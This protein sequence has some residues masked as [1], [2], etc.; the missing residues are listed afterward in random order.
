ME[1]SMV[2]VTASVVDV[3]RGFEDGVADWDFAA[4][5]IVALEWWLRGG[6]YRHSATQV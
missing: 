5:G 4:E 2:G 3:E 6:R 1:G